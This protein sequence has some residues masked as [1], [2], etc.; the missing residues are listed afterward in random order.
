MA[1]GEERITFL[2][3]KDFRKQLEEAAKK[4]RLTLS[5]LIR[6]ALQEWLDNKRN[7]EEE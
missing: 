5:N 3:P 1:I 7:R 2:A 6:M 4:R